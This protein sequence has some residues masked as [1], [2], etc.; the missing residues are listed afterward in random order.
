MREISGI[1]FADPDGDVIEGDFGQLVL[2]DIAFSSPPIPSMQKGEL[3]GFV[4]PQGLV[5]LIPLPEEFVYGP[6]SEPANRSPDVSVYRLVCNIPARDGAPPPNPPTEYLQAALNKYGPNHLS[7]NP[8]VNPNPIRIT[9]TIW[10][11]RFRAHA[12][13]ADRFFTRFGEHTSSP[14][15]DQPNGGVVFLVGDAAHIHSPAGGQGMNLGIR[16]AVGLAAV[17]KQHSTT[18]KPTNDVDKVL[19]DYA[20]ARHERALAIIHLTKRMQGVA[21]SIQSRNLGSIVYLVLVTLGKFSFIRGRLAWRL[22]G[23]ATR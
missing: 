5:L 4:S 11:S 15:L 14:P 16:D 9:E 12:A 17:L 2:A 21:T 3:G 22:S 19:N 6:S 18:N 8:S 13:I 1:G 23:L 20:T 7:S 10:S